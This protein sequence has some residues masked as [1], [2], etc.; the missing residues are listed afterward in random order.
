MPE[1]MVREVESTGRPQ[2]R[3]TIAAPRG[4]VVQELGVR[5]GMTLMA[6]QTV[7]QINGIDRVWL[8][9]AVPEA[10]A[11]GV[12]VGQP[13]QARLA[14]LSGQTLDGRVTA[15]LPSLNEAA[16]TLRV[17][18]ELP[19]PGL[20]LRPGLSAQVTLEGGA[21]EP[22]LRVPSEAVIRTGRRALVI[23]AEDGGRFRPVEVA[24]GAEVDGDTVV[25]RGLSEGQNVVTS[26]QFLIDSEASLRGIIARAASQPAAAPAALHEADARIEE[27]S[28]TQALI[29]HN[30]FPT[31]GMR[32]MTMAFRLARPE[33]AQGL[34][35]GDKVRVGLRQTDTGLVIETLKKQGGAS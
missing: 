14:A 34:K 19:N 17:R 12:R 2:A 33:L 30:D 24:T 10:L 23:V 32:G 4:G 6:G 35:P 21:S 8:E 9:V 11:A 27:I 28:P 1:A 22:A 25:T 18:V 3:V 16:R 5:A 31:L 20:R 7:A 29:E 15:L 26:G 13:A